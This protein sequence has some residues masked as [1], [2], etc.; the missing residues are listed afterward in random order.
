M[1][2]VGDLLARAD[3]AS[4]LFCSQPEAMKAAMRFLSRSWKE[5]RRNA[6]G[7]MVLRRSKATC[8]TS[9]NLVDIILTN[10]GYRDSISHQEDY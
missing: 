3:A 1:K 6:K 7:T 2:V 9:A 5:R 8:T 10:N 4:F